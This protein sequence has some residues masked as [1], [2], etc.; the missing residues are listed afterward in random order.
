MKRRPR[1]IETRIRRLCLVL[2]SSAWCVQVSAAQVCLRWILERG[3]TIAVGTGS[4]PA[5]AASYAKENLGLW[6]FALSAAEVTSINALA[7]PDSSD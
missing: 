3:C 7:K 5:K 4:D 6:G 2:R 1:V